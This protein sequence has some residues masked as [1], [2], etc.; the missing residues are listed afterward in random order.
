MVFKNV[1]IRS[2]EPN[3]KDLANPWEKDY[4]QSSDRAK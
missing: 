2:R 1:K 4:T 3:W